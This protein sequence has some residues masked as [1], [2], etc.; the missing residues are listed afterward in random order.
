MAEAVVVSAGRSGKDDNRVD[1]LST[2]V[3]VAQDTIAVDRTECL[4]GDTVQV[5]W[6]VHSFP[7]HERD[8]IGMFEVG[9]YPGRNK[10]GEGTESSES[11]RVVTMDS[12]L[13]SRLRGDTSREV[14][15]HGL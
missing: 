11:H 3:G 8:F 13:D 2:L 6:E 15:C 1:T 10:N 14:W 12:L 9:E 7:L 4:V 5:T